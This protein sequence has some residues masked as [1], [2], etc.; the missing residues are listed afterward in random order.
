MGLQKVNAA[1]A[2]FQA[3][4]GCK[5]AKG[6]KAMIGRNPGQ[7]GQAGTIPYIVTHDGRTIRYPDPK[8]NLH[9]TVKF[10]IKENKIVDVVKFDI[11]NVSMVTKGANTGRVGILVRKEMHPGSF[12]IV[13][14][15]DARGHEFATRESNVFCIGN[16]EKPLIKLPR[17]RG[18]KK[19]IM[20]E[21]E[22]MLKNN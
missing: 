15:K 12:N 10:D 22:D 16:G 14:L 5:K 11:G 2:K 21:R 19:S 20:E 6:S 4:Q 8:I 9:D 17:T 3:P 7:K 13:H 1:D 18:I